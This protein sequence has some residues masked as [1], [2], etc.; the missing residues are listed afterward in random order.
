MSFIQNLPLATIFGLLGNTISFMVFLSPIP[1]FY[2]IHKKKSTESFQCVPYVVAL[3][4][5]ML[6]ILYAVFA[7]NAT[8]LKTIN[9]FGIFIE[10]IY[11][12][13]F[14]IYAT[15]ESRITTAKLIFAMNIAGFGAIA[16]VTFFVAKT[17]QVRIKILGWICLIFSLC[18]FVAPLGVLRQVIRTKSVKYMPFLLSFF[19]TISAVMWFFYGLVRKDMYVALPN[20]L[21]FSFG[22]VQMGLYVKYRD[23]RKSMEDLIEEKKMASELKIVDHHI[24][25]VVKLAP[26][27][28]LQASQLTVLSDNNNNS[29]NL[30][31]EGSYS[32]EIRNCNQEMIEKIR[33][34]G[35][36]EV[37]APPSNLV[38][39]VA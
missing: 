1:T 7:P 28:T 17:T 27:G 4:S 14:L 37:V 20:V 21:G 25:E 29:Y 12:T 23:T 5:S 3:F 9:S 26:Q 13:I 8:F 36:V 11:I 16:F 32:V 22:I 6:W 18:V 35:V 31:N 38:A 10:T 19:L 30:N 39:V 15:K 24:I 34:I 2:R 33:K